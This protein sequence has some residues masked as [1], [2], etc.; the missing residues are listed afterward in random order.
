MRFTGYRVNGIDGNSYNVTLFIDDDKEYTLNIN[1]PDVKTE[2]DL[3][4]EINIVA[5]DYIRQKS[6]PHPLSHLIGN[7]LPPDISQE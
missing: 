2:S 6:I 7:K 4:T 5:N 3:A 1:L